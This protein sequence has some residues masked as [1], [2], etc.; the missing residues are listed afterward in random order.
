MHPEP[1]ILFLMRLLTHPEGAWSSTF[2]EASDPVAGFT[3]AAVTVVA[4]AVQLWL[5]YRTASQ[6]VQTLEDSE[7]AVHVYLPVCLHGDPLFYHRF[8]SD[9]ELGY[10]TARNSLQEPPP[11]RTPRT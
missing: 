1:V 2:G 4:L 6:G 3:L 9:D 11:N 5:I 8:P 7:A 10:A